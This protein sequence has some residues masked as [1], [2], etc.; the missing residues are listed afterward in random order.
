[1]GCLMFF[2]GRGSDLWLVCAHDD[3]FMWYVFGVIVGPLLA[4]DSVSGG[5][6]AIP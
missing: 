3:T 4:V 2:R 1:M 6:L 5:R